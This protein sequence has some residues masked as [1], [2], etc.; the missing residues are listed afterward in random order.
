M[1]VYITKRLNINK[2]VF[3]DPLGHSPRRSGIPRAMQKP[4]KQRTGTPWVHGS[5][6]AISL[7]VKYKFTFQVVNLGV[8]CRHVSN[9]NT[10]A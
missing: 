10:D 6:L 2:C 4:A 1:R 3:R 8:I 5:A 9:Q 7:L